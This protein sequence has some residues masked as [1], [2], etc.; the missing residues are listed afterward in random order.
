MGGCLW[1]KPVASTHL[2]P[3]QVVFGHQWFPYLYQT[4]P[5]TSKSPCHLI[6]SSEAMNANKQSQPCSDGISFFLLT[7]ANPCSS[8]SS[9]FSVEIWRKHIVLF[10]APLHLQMGDAESP[11]SPRKLGYSRA[12]PI[13]ETAGHPGHLPP[14]AAC[15]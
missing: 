9:A 14:G 8:W 5:R 6:P 1:R 2:I 13:G 15:L 11:W 3:T 7:R 10:T 12:L 4:M